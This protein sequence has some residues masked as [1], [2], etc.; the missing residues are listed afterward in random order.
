MSPKIFIKP[1]GS[2][3][4]HPVTKADA[5]SFRKSKY[6]DDEKCK[7]CKSCSV[8]YTVN[9]QCVHCARL[10]AMHF[11]NLMVVGVPWPEGYH[12]TDEMREARNAFPPD[13]LAPGNP[14]DAQRFGGSLWVR[15]E[16][17]SKA[18]HL[19]VRKVNGGCWQC[20]KQSI[21]HDPN[22]AAARQ[23]GESV[24]TP[25]NECPKCRTRSERRVS[26]NRC[27]GCSP[28]GHDPNRAAA[29]RN[30]DKTYT[31]TSECPDCGQKATRN[32]V[33]NKCYGCHPHDGRRSP[34]TD[35]LIASNPTMVISRSDAKLL[36]FTAYRTGAACKRGHTGWRYVSTSACIDCMKEIG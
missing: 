23:N 25:T 18:G 34:E 12:I 8:K 2:P 20:E 4:P 1:N 16:P 36:G 9:S 7:V 31:P 14:S 19:G 3:S 27:L 11:Y 22:R 24:Y 5:L 21:S 6:D 13:T 28:S 33:T 32:V 29:R 26:D 35:Q 17:C 30:G 15:V 10:D